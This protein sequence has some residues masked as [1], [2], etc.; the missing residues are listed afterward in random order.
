MINEYIDLGKEIRDVA[1]E[2]LE[3]AGLE[4]IYPVYSSTFKH[5][6]GQDLSALLYTNGLL[7]IMDGNYEGSEDLGTVTEYEL[8]GDYDMIVTRMY[9]WA[10][11]ESYT[12]ALD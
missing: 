7:Y 5:M 11:T 8:G 10:D 6:L 12:V 1:N 2:L 3:D 9:Q 4:G